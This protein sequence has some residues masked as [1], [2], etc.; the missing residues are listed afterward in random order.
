MDL[1]SRIEKDRFLGRLPDVIGNTSCQ[2]RAVPDLARSVSSSGNPVRSI[3]RPTTIALSSV[4]RLAAVAVENSPGRRA[5][6][7]P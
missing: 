4:C 3:T 7:N 2:R 5:E 1:S 6:V